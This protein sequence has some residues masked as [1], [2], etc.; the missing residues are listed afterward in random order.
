[1][2]KVYLFLFCLSTMFGSS[3]TAP[4]CSLDPT[5]VSSNKV[6][7][8]PDSATNFVSGIVGGQYLQNITVKVPKDTTISILGHLCFTKVTLT[9]PSSATNYNLPPGLS[10]AVNTS[11]LQ[12]GT[13]N[14]A[15][16][17]QFPGNA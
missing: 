7:V 17:F 4:T 5:F 3:Q 12:N 14:G 11:S 15:P 8:W 1:M 6:G 2:K 10:F 16:S 9:N 13:V